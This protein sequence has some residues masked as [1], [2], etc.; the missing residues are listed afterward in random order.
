MADL[1]R[2]GQGVLP[3]TYFKYALIKRLEGPQRY[4]HFVQIDLAAA[5]SG[6]SVANLYLQNHDELDIYSL[7]QL[8]D[9]PAVTVNGEVGY[10]E[11]TC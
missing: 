11:P 5:L 2:E 1:V 8:R 6:N 10:P 3:H 7:D 4:A 9:L